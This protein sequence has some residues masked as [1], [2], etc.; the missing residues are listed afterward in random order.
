M[1][2]F[3]GITTS[4]EIVQRSA[5]QEESVQNTGMFILVATSVPGIVLFQGSGQFFKRYCAF[6]VNSN[7]VI[8]HLSRAIPHRHTHIH[9]LFFS[10][11]LFLSWRFDNVL[12]LSDR[13][14]PAKENELC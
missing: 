8:A 3:S 13:S 5:E 4:G 2:I 1:S 10:P 6:T 7:S 12:A 11:S 9:T 14:C